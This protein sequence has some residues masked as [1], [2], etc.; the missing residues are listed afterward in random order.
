[1][2][3]TLTLLILCFCTLMVHGQRRFGAAIEAGLTASQLDGDLSAGY[4]KLGLMAGLRSNINLR[5]KT[6]LSI[7]FL[8]AQRG[9][10][11]EIKQNNPRVYAITLNYLE[12]PVLFNYAD[13]QV[14]DGEDTWYRAYLSAGLSYGRLI[15][16]KLRDDG[17]FAQA[18]VQPSNPPPGRDNYLNNQDLSLTLG[19]TVFFK[20]NIG[21]SV[22]W[23]RSATF[24]YNPKKWDPAPL[25]RGWNAHSLTFSLLYRMF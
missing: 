3:Q 24:V 7:G 10:Q 2:R 15:S 4:N 13:W 16:T 14:K 20:R 5:E 6:H 22:R 23:M 8:F 11:D 12:L 17:L 18:V 19:G 1:M 25:Q 21:L 9:A